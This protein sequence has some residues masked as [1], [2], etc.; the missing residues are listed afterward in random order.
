MSIIRAD[1]RSEFAIFAPGPVELD[2]VMSNQ[3]AA[4]GNHVRY[5]VCILLDARD[6]DQRAIV[7]DAVA[8]Q[9]LS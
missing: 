3:A 1:L 2:E 5:P 7:Y 4:A 9:A 6:A 8:T